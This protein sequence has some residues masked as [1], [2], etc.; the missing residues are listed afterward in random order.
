M[1]LRSKIFLPLLLAGLLFAVY[2]YGFWQPRLYAMAEESN[3]SSIARHIDTVAEGLVYHLLGNQLDAVYGDLD[4]LL[5]KNEEWLSIELFDQQG[6]LLYPLAPTPV[7]TEHAAHEIATFQQDIRYL[8]SKLGRLVVKVC[9]SEKL[10]AINGFQSRLLIDLGLGATL[11]LL[12][13]GYLLELIVQKPLSRLALAARQVAAGEFNTPLPP[14]GNDEVGSLIGSFARMRETIREDTGSLLEMNGQLR[15]EVAEREEAEK[16]IRVSETRFRTLAEKSPNMIFINQ[17]GRLV[18]VNAKCIES[19]GYSREEFLA[20][21]FDFRTLI[22]PVSLPLVKEAYR[23]Q[24]NGEDVDPYEYSLLTKG[25]ELIEVILSSKLIDYD[26]Q[27][28][29]L[30][31]ITDITER[32]RMEEELRLLSV[33]L[34]ALV[35]ERTVE[36]AQ[37][38]QELKSSEERFRAIFEH[39]G[40]GILL[41]DLEGRRLAMGND[42]IQRMLGYDQAELTRLRVT[43]LHAEAD[44]PHA[45]AEFEKIAGNKAALATATEVAFKR[46]DNTVFYANVTPAHLTINNKH[47]LM[48]IFRDVTERRQ[49]EAEILKLNNAL[50]QRIVELEEAKVLAESGVRARTEFLANMSHEL[51]TPLNAIIGFSQLLLDDLGGTL[52]QQQREYIQVILQSGERL[53]ETYREI[54]EITRLESGMMQ[55]RTESFLVA[56]LLQA[57]LLAIK[58]KAARQGVS[59]EQQLDFPLDTMIEADREKLMRAVGNLLGNAVKFSPEGGAVR[60]VARL[61]G[62]EGREVKDEEPGTRDEGGEGVAENSSFVPAAPAGQPSSFLEIGVVD[63]GIGIKPEDL[64]RLFKPF[65]QLEAVYTK[66]YAGSGLGLALA[67]KLV[68]LHGG[69]L[70]VESEFGQG[71]RFTITVPLR[72]P[73]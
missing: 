8:E 49:A 65:N 14:A 62:G 47:Y 31:I 59:L 27:P 19:M 61:T 58:E 23:R 48:G 33:H 44:L 20:R 10:K 35:E 4:N 1:G 30:G 50:R 56:D 5:Q 26:D 57:S 6:R 29:I 52:N 67:K 46:K 39:A 25:G 2:L 21:D 7:P 13:T 32:K 16:A 69:W 45:M 18:Y 64:E 9:R 38:N 73:E 11:V 17:Q 60:L 3:H 68:E 12:V 41:V 34:E 51:S 63:E 36:L 22:A 55:L 54:I 37:L 24:L 70:G 72:Q 28:A 42:S 53:H 15:R 71:S 40:D 66:K 43:D